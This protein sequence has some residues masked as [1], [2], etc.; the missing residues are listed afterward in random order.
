MQGVVAG[1]DLTAVG[2]KVAERSRLIAEAQGAWL[3]LI[4]VVEPVGEAFIAPGLARILF[5][6]R[7]R[8]AEALAAWVNSRSQMPAELVVVK[9]SPAN[10]LCVRS[11]GADF[12]VMGSSAVDATKVG[13]VARRVARKARRSVLI[14]RRQPR[15]PYR[16]VVAAV[17]FSE[18]SRAAITQAFVLAP[19]ADVT[20]VF[21]LPTRFDPLLADAGLFAEE[22]EASRSVRLRLAREAMDRFVA[23]WE[24]RVK[25]LV[26]DG[27]P[28]ETID[29]VVRRRTADLVT[30]AS[31]GQGAT[32]MVLL[33]T[34]AEGLLDTVPCDVSIARVGSQ[35][36]RP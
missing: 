26:V 15:G 19:D 20:A 35:F 36:R 29:E 33:G 4:H 32:K 23:P 17:D 13:P 11:Q 2:R 5:E 8:L 16:R 10:E 6:H 28:F 31:R 34:V 9:G 18:L 27:P 14:V 1:V 12:I 25:G 24:G 30:V 3:R 7:K 22:V 21:S